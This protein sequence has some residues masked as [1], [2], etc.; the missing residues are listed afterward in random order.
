ME[1]RDAESLKVFDGEKFAVWKYHMEIC[2]DDKDVTPIVNGT[3]PQP[4]D[5]VPEAEKIVWQKAN[6]LAMRMIS[7]AVSLPIL[8]NLVNCPTAAC[9]WNTLCAFYQQKSRENIFMIQGNFFEY[10]M[11]AGDS[12][13]T[14]VNKVLSM[15]NLLKDMGQPVQEDVLLTKII[16]S[17]PASY[18]DV[19]AAWTNVPPKEQ[20]VAN[21]KVRLLQMENIMT[22]Q[23]AATDGDSAF[24]T[25]SS[26]ITSKHKKQGGEKSTE[27]IKDL[28]SRTRCYNCGEYDHWTAE[29]P[30]PRQDKV[31]FSNQKKHRPDRSSKHTKGKRSEACVA[32][33]DHR[34]SSSHESSTDS[35]DSCAFMTINKASYALTVNLDKQ[36]WFADSGATE[37]M[38]EHREWFSTF[39]PISEGTWSVTVADD[40]HLWVRGVGDIQITRTIDGEQKHGI[41][42]KVLFIPDLKRNLFSIGLTSKAGL[43]FQTFGDK[44]AL[45]RDLGKGPKVMEGAL[46][47]TSYKLA[48]QPLIPSTTSIRSKNPAEI[49]Q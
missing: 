1:K 15:A 25:R 5:N 26:K 35:D 2:F 13:N 28:K 38:T 48:I 14:H 42:Q 12:I 11:Q 46:V 41:L 39:T 9:M 18:N 49:T 8:E 47:G 36:A 7:S 24:F 31:K 27:Y 3:I 19:V 16:C 44:C 40:R 33:T 20:T 4:P 43:S 17:L 32:T 22:L 10:K 37:H 23:N 21:L 30:R 29:C 45:Y 34:N 6:T